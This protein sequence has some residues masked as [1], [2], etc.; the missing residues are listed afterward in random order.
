MCAMK[1]KNKSGDPKILTS[2]QWGNYINCVSQLSI[3]NR[4]HT[5]RQ[6][7]GFHSSGTEL[8]GERVWLESKGQGDV[9]EDI[10]RKPGGIH[11]LIYTKEAPCCYHT[12]N[13]G[14][15][16]WEFYKNLPK[17]VNVD[18]YFSGVDGLD[19]FDLDVL[20]NVF[21]IEDNYR[22]LLE[23]IGVDTKAFY[24]L[25]LNKGTEY[26][27]ISILGITETQ[28]N[29]TLKKNTS[30]KNKISAVV[31]MLLYGKPKKTIIE[32]MIQKSF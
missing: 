24:D 32:Q 19:L 13:G 6:S 17:D 16:C 22:T 7:F 29:E 15:C 28:Y 20:K 18:V 11:L 21:G 2:D 23:V 14:I 25:D 26:N 10:K 9:I 8:N 31:D 12:G 27:D 30:Y 1:K 5:E 4:E 3:L